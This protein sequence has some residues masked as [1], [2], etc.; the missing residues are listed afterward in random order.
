MRNIFAGLIA[1]L[2]A[3]P[4]TAQPAP[5]PPSFPQA[6]AEAVQS[7]GEGLLELGR[8]A[9]TGVGEVGGRQTPREMAPNSDPLGRINGR[10][11]NRVQN[12]LRNRVD[13][14]YNPIANAAAPFSG[15]EEAV[16][17]G[18]RPRPRR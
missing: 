5:R 4:L 15:A 1:S 7:Q 10:V 9:D 14:S 12:R 11:E 3:V 8:T 18:A 17:K 2:W 6:A 16:R 13:E